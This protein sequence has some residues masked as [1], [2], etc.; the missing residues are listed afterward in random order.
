MR[1]TPTKRRRT[2]T[3]TKFGERILASIKG[4][5]DAMDRGEAPPP[6]EL[7]GEPRE[8]TAEDVRSLRTQV[9]VTQRAFADF[10]GVSQ[11]LV[12]SWEQGL[13]V[14]TRLARRM[15]DQISKDVEF[16]KGQ[17]QAKS[18]RQPRTQRTVGARKRCAMTA[19]NVEG[20]VP[21]RSCPPPDGDV[22]N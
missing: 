13:R 6:R 9:N 3:D 15:L 5:L 1:K 21:A 4:Q 7:V 2:T 18:D 16:W 17:G 11:I 14:P 10:V 20:E 8:Y 22:V 19:E 12:S